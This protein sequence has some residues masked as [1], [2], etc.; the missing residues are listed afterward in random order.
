MAVNRSKI[1]SAQPQLNSSST[2]QK[3]Y[4]AQ[5]NFSLHE[6]FLTRLVYWQHGKNSEAYLVSKPLPPVLITFQSCSLFP[7][8][9]TVHSMVMA[10]AKFL[11]PRGVEYFLPSP[12]RAVNCIL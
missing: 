8:V 1:S 7:S 9:V 2:P 11:V 6:L 4:F 3:C 12:G 10:S 5:Y